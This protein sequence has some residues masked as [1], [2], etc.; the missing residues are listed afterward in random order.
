[1]S[2]PQTVATLNGGPDTWLDFEKHVEN[3][4]NRWNF[5]GNKF[6]FYYAGLNDVFIF[7]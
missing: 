1:M 4:D 7:F 5:R 2:E 6:K 3:G